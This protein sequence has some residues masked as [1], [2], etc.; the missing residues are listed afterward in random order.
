MYNKNEIISMWAAGMYDIDENDV[1]DVNF[2]LSIIGQSPKRILE[3]GCGSGRY[4]IHLAKSDHK[5]VGLDF[6]EFMLEKIDAKLDSKENI[7]WR[8]SDV[9][10]DEWG[11]GFDIVLL[12]A[13]FL[14][15]IVSDMEYEKAQ[16]LLIRKSAESLVSGGHLL[17]DYG[18]TLYSEKWYGNVRKMTL[19]GSRFD[20]SNSMC[21][22]IRD[23]KLR[24]RIGV[25][26]YMIF[27]QK[28]TLQPS[29]KF[30]NGCQICICNKIN[31]IRNK[32]NMAE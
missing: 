23:M 29:N 13:N 4:L 31:V 8:K 9:I 27:L 12:A 17:I 11:N 30:M 21:T 3:I 24:L 7:E 26:L 1:T 25:H 19:L 5:V 32:I 22:F 6:D 28:N 15:N 18:Y 20:K 14:F 16:E 2:A 10:Q